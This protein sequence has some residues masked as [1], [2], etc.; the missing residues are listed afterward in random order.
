[1]LSDDLLIHSTDWPHS[2]WPQLIFFSL[3]LVRSPFVRGLMCATLLHLG[4]SS[5]FTL[6]S[7]IARHAPASLVVTYAFCL[8]ALPLAFLL[9]IDNRAVFRI[10]FTVL[11]FM[12][13]ICVV[14]PIVE[15]VTGHRSGV[16]PS[17]SF[18]YAVMFAFPCI[19]AVVLRRGA[20]KPE[21]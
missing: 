3:D 18:S 7:A 19:V 12:A 13:L 2:Q 21:I 4:I 6:T 16:R 10:A 17:N 20:V 11:A 1:M 15:V 8:L 9:L 14:A 5:I